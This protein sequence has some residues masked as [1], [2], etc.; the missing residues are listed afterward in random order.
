MTGPMD[1]GLSMMCG[2]VCGWVVTTLGGNLIIGPFMYWYA[3]QQLKE[4]E[5]DVAHWDDTVQ[6]GRRT[7][8]LSQQD[9]ERRIKRT[10]ISLTRWKI[11]MIPLFGPTLAILHYCRIFSFSKQ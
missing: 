1:G 3:H 7:F 6:E 4:D 8:I 11:F 5:Y 2:A 9:L 10:K